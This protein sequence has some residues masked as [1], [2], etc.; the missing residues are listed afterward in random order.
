MLFNS[1]DFLIFAPIVIGIYFII[2]KRIKY[3]WL[4]ITSYYF[5]MCWN[6]YYSLLIAFSTVVTYLSGVLL[7]R[8]KDSQVV[9]KRLILAASL[10]LNLGILSVF[11]Y[12]NFL[13]VNINRILSV[14]GIVAK[15]PSLDILLPVG[16][17]FYTFQALSYTIDVY[18]GD[19]APEKNLFRYALFVSFF[20]QLVAGPIE[21]SG[22]LLLQL[23]ELDK[24][25]LWSFDSIV[26][27]S[28]VAIWGFFLKMVI[29][30]RI[31]IFVDAVWDNYQNYGAIMLWLATMGF[32]IQIY[33]DFAGYSSIA[34]GVSKIMGIEL[35]ENFDTPYFARSIKEFWGRWHISLSTWFKDY[36]YIPLGG[37]RCSK[38]RNYI[39]LMITFV[40]SGLWHGAGWSY[41][42][43]GGIH[44]LY[45]VIG[46]ISRPIKDK[47]FKMFNFKTDSL[48]WHIGECI[49]TFNLLTFALIFFRA[50][51]LSEAKNFIYKIISDFDLGRIV[52]QGLYGINWDDLQV[53]VLIFSLILLLLVSLIKY[54]MKQTIDEFLMN[55]TIVFRWISIIFVIFI[56]IMYGEYGSQFDA[57]QFIYFQF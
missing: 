54:V 56:I 30:D 44:G 11:K 1:Y 23:K 53:N 55:Q 13:I 19:I 31:S 3:I 36:L 29:S 22:R 32:A 18:R 9:Q 37:S 12:G 35:M 42:A 45:Q 7:G 28:I 33:C 25:R 48:S 34:I 52:N 20:P 21:R 27:G 14:I 17:S 8:C 51:S 49:T 16:I 6:P 50:E 5:Y 57:S 10:V 15:V 43:W 46:K 26:R 40:V 47:I 4:L 38:L 41:V 39:N 24:R 2:P